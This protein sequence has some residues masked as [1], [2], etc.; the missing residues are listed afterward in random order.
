[1]NL[2]T[3]TIAVAI[4]VALV[5]LFAMASCTTIPPGKVG[6]VVHQQGTNRGVSAYHATT[7]RVFYMP[8]FTRIIEYPTFIQTIKWTRNPKEGGLNDQTENDTSDESFTFATMKGVAIN[9]DVSLA[10]QLDQET[11]PKFYVQFRSDDLKTFAYG[12]L[13]NEVRNAM[14]NIGGK[15]TVEEVMGEKIGQFTAEVEQRVQERVTPFGVQI[16]QFGF[17]GQPRPPDQ[18]RDG[19]N[20]VSA[21]QYLAQQKQNEL[22]QSIADAKKRV[23]DAQGDAD[24]AIT[25]AKGQSEAN[26]LLNESLSDK[27][28]EKIRLDNQKSLIDKWNGQLPVTSVGNNGAG[29]L[30]NL[31]PGPKQ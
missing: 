18:I 20:N 28:L 6:I 1:M 9:A 12:Y 24:S 31:T 16:G 13:H 25:R 29:M 30:Y 27:V 8:Y 17:I 2:S 14:N 26:R 19:I 4:A 23:A 7:G 10:F 22:Q 15:Y 11:I 5:M 3:R 21:A